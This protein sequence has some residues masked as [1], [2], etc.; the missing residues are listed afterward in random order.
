MRDK[1][2]INTSF[3][4]KEPKFEPKQCV[5][6][7]AVPM[8]HRSFTELNENLLRDN[9]VIERYKD[10]MYWADDKFHCIL[11]YDQEQGDGILIESEGS[12]YARYSQYIPH[13]KDILEAH[14]Q[15]M[16]LSELKRSVDTF[17]DEWLKQTGIEKNI[18]TT[19]NELF[20]EPGLKDLLA[21][22][23][24]DSVLE[25]PEIASCCCE[26]DFIEAGKKDI[27]ETKLYCPLTIVVDDHDYNY[28]LREEPSYL[29]TQYEDWINYKISGSLEYDEKERGLIMWNDDEH[30]SQ[31]IYSILPSVES[32][33]GDLYGVVTIRSYG[34]LDNAEFIDISKYITGQLSDGWGESFEQHEVKAGDNDIYISFWNSENFYLKKE[35]DMFP[36]QEC[37]MQIGGQS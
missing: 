32:A 11:M 29:Y 2:I 33:N 28:D 1:L 6:E 3:E 16:A 10:L 25:R 20:T 5:V 17:V 23:V 26:N 31:K 14:E 30:L 34:E 12:D 15:N 8:T 4:R 13:A 37:P 9:S 18:C 7:K 24:K 35:S 21:N 22:I 27:V 19:F 36:E